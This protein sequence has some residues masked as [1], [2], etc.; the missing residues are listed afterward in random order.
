VEKA[1]EH[2]ASETMTIRTIKSDQARSQWRALLDL[3]SQEDVDVVIERHGKPTVAVINY[4]AYRAVLSA[5]TEV[6]AAGL[7][8]SNGKRMADALAQLATL[9]DRIDIADPVQWQIEERRER[10][11]PIQEP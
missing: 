7:A 11:L 10:S 3:A 1:T 4:D 2:K 6:R 8:Q 9:P 5:L